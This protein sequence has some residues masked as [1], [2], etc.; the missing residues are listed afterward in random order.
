MTSQYRTS[1]LDTPTIGSFSA[2]FVYSVAATIIDAS[3]D[4]CLAVDKG[5]VA[6]M[7]TG[8]SR[9]L[10][11]PDRFDSGNG[12]TCSEFLKRVTVCF[13]RFARG[14]HCRP[15]QD[16]QSRA[17]SFQQQ[18]LGLLSSRPPSPRLHGYPGV[19]RA[20]FRRGWQQALTAVRGLLCCVSRHTSG[21]AE[22]SQDMGQLPGGDIV[23]T[24]HAAGGPHFCLS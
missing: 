14:R 1:A 5:M 9:S 13:F 11:A 20:G 2:V 21:D 12:G 6:D 7:A 19:Q 24:Y 10:F 18:P 17:R 22:A 15:L 3:R 16:Q 23:Y 4:I 8:A